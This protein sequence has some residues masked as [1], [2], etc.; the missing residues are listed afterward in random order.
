[1]EEVNEQ[2]QDID[3]IYPTFEFMQWVQ[4]VHFIFIFYK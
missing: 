1:M 2:L 3:D 4:G